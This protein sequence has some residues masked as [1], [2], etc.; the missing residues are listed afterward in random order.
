MKGGAGWGQGGG[1]GKGQGRVRGRVAGRSRTTGAMRGVKGGAGDRAQEQSAVKQ[2]QGS[3]A[4]HNRGKA[5][6]APTFQ[7]PVE[8]QRGVLVHL[9]L[10]WAGR[11]T[12][13]S[14]AWCVFE[15]AGCFVLRHRPQQAP[16]R[17]AGRSPMAATHRERHT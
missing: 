8:A 9:L 14:A 4:S 1:Q 16:Q 17:H 13:G 5:L 11:G 6:K 3:A 2:R 12:R 10:P 15:G 7:L